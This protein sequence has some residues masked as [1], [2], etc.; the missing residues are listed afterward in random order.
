[1]RTSDGCLVFIHIPKTAGQTLHFVAL[2]G[3][4]E[5]ETIHCNI[6]D[7]PV[8]EEMQ[9]IPVSE[10][11]RARLVWGHIPYGVHRQIPR[12]CEYL[13]MLREPTARVISV[14]KHIRK[15]PGH[16]L[17]HRLEEEQVGLEL[18]VES[19]MDGGQTENSQTRQL[20]GRQFGALDRDALDEA[21]RNLEKFLLIG[22][23][24]RFEESFV[25]L[26]RSLGLH[27]PPLY[28]YRNVNVST[29]LEVSEQAI[30]LIRDRNALDLDLYD[31]ARNLFDDRVARQG[32]SFNLEVSVL[33][34]GRPLSRAVGESADIIRKLPPTRAVRRS[35][36]KWRSRSTG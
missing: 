15:T 18:Y 19:A 9:K 31:F 13:T 2:R 30:S 33:K 25:M 4:P 7:R 17:H 34:S 20:S 1:M 3:Y 10:R 28:V 11:S 32:R 35:L 6:L 12:R 23:T 27:T 14:Y 24:E 5:Q 26:R 29:P 16:E 8:D 21:K 36:R 22:L